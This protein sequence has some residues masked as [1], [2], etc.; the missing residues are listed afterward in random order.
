MHR[1]GHRL[2]GADGE[3][4]GREGSKRV[5][6]GVGW[7]IRGWCRRKRE[8]RNSS[9]LHSPRVRVEALRHLPRQQIGQYSRGAPS[10]GDHVL[11]LERRMHDTLHLLVW[12]HG[13]HVVHL[14]WRLHMHLREREGALVGRVRVVVLRS[15]GGARL[16]RRGAVQVGV[17]VGETVL[18]L[19]ARVAMI[20][21]GIVYIKFLYTC[22][23]QYYCCVFPRT[24]MCYE[25]VH[26]H[27]RNIV[28]LH[29]QRILQSNQIAE[30]AIRHKM[31]WRHSKN[32][33]WR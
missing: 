17:R 11:L 23:V 9:G 4:S 7:N 3:W 30:R 8:K 31:K 26:T 20:L 15:G 5:G 21:N 13:M 2:H 27:D 28:V 25:L 10:S 33:I 14:A 18:A 19:Q 1:A 24:A 12:R 29:I 32:Q 16:G 22:L 6:V